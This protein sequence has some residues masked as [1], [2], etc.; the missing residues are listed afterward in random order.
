MGGGT[1]VFEVNRGVVRGLS[2]RGRGNLRRYFSPTSQL[3]SIPAWAGEPW[4]L[5]MLS[6]PRRGLSPRGRGN[7]RALNP[8]DP[9]QRSIPAWAGEPTTSCCMMTTSRVYPRVG[10]GTPALPGSPGSRP[11]LSPRGRGNPCHSKISG[12][13]MRSIPAWAGEPMPGGADPYRGGV[14]PRVGG[15][16]GE[17]GPGAR[18]M[19]GL[20]PRGRGNPD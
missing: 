3:G 16:T 19:D 9:P 13:A 1:Q 10:G 7:L 6:S 5:S 12:S 17:S 2:P 11:G 15:G 4:M 14:Y 8:L 18:P 20:S